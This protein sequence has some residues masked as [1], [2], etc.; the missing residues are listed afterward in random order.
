MGYSA[1]AS[2]GAGGMCASTSPAASGGSTTSRLESDRGY[3]GEGHTARAGC[4]PERR[5]SERV[6]LANR[7]SH[8]PPHPRV[9]L[10]SYHFPPDRTVGARRWEK[11]AHFFT[12][13]GWGVD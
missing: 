10:I 13:R 9:F 3:R 7:S 5:M 1:D 2:A 12:E 6:L 11:L 8:L 4:R